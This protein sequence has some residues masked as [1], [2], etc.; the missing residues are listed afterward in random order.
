MT[1]AARD[2]SGAGRVLLVTADNLFLTHVFQS[3]RGVELY[4][5]DSLDNL[6][7]DSFD[8]VV[9][10]GVLPDQLPDSDLL[11]VNPPHGTDFFSIAGEAEPTGTVTINQ[12][13][14]RTRNL[15]GYMDS[16]TVNTL[17]VLSGVEWGTV[18]AQVDGYPLVVAGEVGSRQVVILPF[19]V[20]Y[21]NSDIVLQPAWPILIAE[22]SAWFSP[23]RVT[24]VTDYLSPGAPVTI[25]FIE[26]ADDAVITRPNGQRVTLSPQGSEAVFADTLT[27]GL[28]RV[29]LRKNGSAF[30]SE[31][32][33]VNLFDPAESQIAPRSSVVI[34]TSAVEEA[35]RE[36]SAKREYWSWVALAG[37]LLLL[38]E[39]WV[40]HRSL[41]RIPRVALTGLHG[42]QPGLRD[43]LRARAAT[44]GRRKSRRVMKTR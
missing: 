5:A 37:L 25:R 22:L 28:Y 18:L 33:A 38:I 20:K 40:Y 26:N 2:R 32:F 1:Y 29:D 9:F 8:L 3:L 24:S 34:G 4:Q 44:L 12:D 30:K 6:P 23:P 21:P 42:G 11:I 13:D 39:W 41:R 15:G 14:T 35:T 43:R 27:P 36:E 10:D 17:S 16:V 19:D 31:Q 7:S